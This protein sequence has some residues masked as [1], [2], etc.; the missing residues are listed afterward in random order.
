M[1]GQPVPTTA[2][3]GFPRLT[4]EN[5]SITSPASDKYNCIAWAYE[6]SNKLM[7]PG[8]P[9]DYY[10]PSDVTGPDELRTLIQLYLDA[11][12]QECDNGEL[13][14]GFKKVAI[15]VNEE[16]PQHAALQLESGRW[17]SKLGIL[18]DIE[19][20]TLKDLEG[21]F[22]GRAVAFLKKQRA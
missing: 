3:L 16:G 2:R 22:Y 1:I 10:W 11:G 14:D 6:L 20:N 7:W 19:H 21:E 13:E 17:S 9:Q 18:Q 15:Y 4:D 8:Y 12:Y 5:H